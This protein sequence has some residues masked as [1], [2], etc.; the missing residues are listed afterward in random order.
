MVADTN[1]SDKIMDKITGA[2]S[3]AVCEAPFSGQC[4]K[5]KNKGYVDPNCW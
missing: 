4:R 2:K 5:R 3:A 1:D